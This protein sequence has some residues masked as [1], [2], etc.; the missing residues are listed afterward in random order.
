MGAEGKK[1]ADEDRQEHAKV[2]F[3]LKNCLNEKKQFCF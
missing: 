2:T 1:I 3:S